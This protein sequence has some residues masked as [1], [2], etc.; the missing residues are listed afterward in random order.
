MRIPG[1]REKD[2]PFAACPRLHLDSLIFVLRDLHSFSRIVYR[3]GCKRANTFGLRVKVYDVTRIELAIAHEF[4]HFQRLLDLVAVNKERSWQ[5]GGVFPDKHL[6][7]ALAFGALYLLLR[8]E[9]K[10]VAS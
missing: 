7:F 5:N 9:R 4:E 6:F 2:E 1:I 10:F 3:S 8:H